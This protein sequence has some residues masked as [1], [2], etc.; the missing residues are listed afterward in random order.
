MTEPVGRVPFTDSRGQPGCSGQLLDV[1][2]GAS[3][4]GPL[5]SSDYIAFCVSKKQRA[6]VPLQDEIQS[7]EIAEMAQS[8]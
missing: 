4:S 2:E 5:D 3:P 7:L 8:Q 1:E 6:P